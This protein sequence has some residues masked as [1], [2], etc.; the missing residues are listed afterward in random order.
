MAKTPGFYG[1]KLLAA[2]WVI[3]FINLAFPA[4]G[5]SVINAYMIQDLGLDRRTL[6]LMVS[7]YML[8]SGL[9]G[10]LVAMVVNRFGVRATLVIGSAILLL[11]TLSMA[12]IVDSGAG[13]V[14]A[15]GLLVGLGVV[16]GGALAAQTGTAFWFVRRRA[17]AIALILSAGGIGGF[18]AA[19]VLSWLIEW[20]DGNW[21]A[22]W[23]LITGMALVS[24]LVAALFVREKPEHLGQQPDGGAAA[25]GSHGKA[26]SRVHITDEIWSFGD[27]LRSPALWLLLISSFGASAGFTQ[28]MAH[29]IPHL[30]DLGIPTDVG[31]KTFSIVV[32]ST[33]LGKL[34]L[35][36]FGDRIDPRYL[37]AITAV[38]FG[39][40]MLVLL[41]ADTVLK[42]NV[43]AVCVGL[44]FG[45]GLVCMMTVLS[46]YF[47]SA[48]YA[49][50]I[51]VTLATQTT[52]GALG[53]FV[54]GDLYERFG[55][56]S[57]PFTATAILCFAGAILLVIIR[58]PQRP[59]PVTE[60]VARAEI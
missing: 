2:F 30:E 6:G 31:S 49:S 40:G 44:G 13:A 26:S 43:F 54:A 3:L 42:M 39:V 25:S 58:P 37:W 5:S 9:P 27:A 28:V 35:G 59:A 7:V 17:L 15:F 34:M 56:Y 23:W 24:L 21:R 55:S 19:R 57:V 45:G 52:V 53:S 14:V 41:H 36:V 50:V 32:V 16:T 18:I 12:T 60:A 22:G 8:M 10:P 20:A 11:G 38:A 4:Y 51:G 1:W 47:G 29:A 33:L 46:N 48:A